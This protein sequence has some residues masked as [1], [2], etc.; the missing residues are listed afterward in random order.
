[1][2]ACVVMLLSG[3]SQADNRLVSS[4]SQVVTVGSYSGPTDVKSFAPGHDYLTDDQKDVSKSL[5]AFVNSGIYNISRVELIFSDTCLAAAR[6]DY[7]Y[8]Q[9]IGAGNKLRVKLVLTQTDDS[10]G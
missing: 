10:S 6:V 3:C 4:D 9:V 2:V 1:M 8:D 5:E 7:R